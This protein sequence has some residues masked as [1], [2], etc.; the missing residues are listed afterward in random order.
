MFWAS[1]TILLVLC[2][3]LGAQEKPPV[4]AITWDL[5]TNANYAAPTAWQLAHYGLEK[6]QVYFL[7]DNRIAIAYPD[8]EGAQRWDTTAL[9]KATKPRYKFH[10]MIFDI[11]KGPDS[12]RELQWDATLKEP[13]LLPIPGIGFALR[14]DDKLMV[15][16][17][18]YQLLKTMQLTFPSMGPLP[19][20]ESYK[21]AVSS[22]GKSLVMCHP[23]A[24]DHAFRGTSI[25]WYDPKTIEQIGKTSD[26][27][28]DL[29][30]EYLFT[31]SD[32]V[33][34]LGRH[35]VA[36]DDPSWKELP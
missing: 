17:S 10:S 12:A 19:N 23:S 9:L 22:S 2:P 6:P 1:A 8:E 25:T 32:K 15:Y 30:C 4:P 34:I 20:Y 14:L 21:I 26:V 33:A 3:L 35:K 13:Q 27:K 36:P 5:S 18:D 24:S 7:D 28:T 16:S 29:V 31:A 11:D